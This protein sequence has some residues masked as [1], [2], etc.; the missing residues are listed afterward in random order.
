M[1]TFA[2][3]QSK[4]LNVYNLCLLLGVNLH[5]SVTEGFSSL[6]M[7]EAYVWSILFTNNHKLLRVMKIKTY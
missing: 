2:V 4:Y 1:L 5:T 6:S 7:N 3:E